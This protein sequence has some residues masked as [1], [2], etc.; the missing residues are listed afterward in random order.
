M[1]CCYQVTKFVS[2]RSGSATA[3]SAWGP[4]NFGPF[5]DFAISVFRE[6]SQPLRDLRIQRV[7]PFCRGFLFYLVFGFLVAWVSLGRPDLSSTEFDTCTGEVSL[8]ISS[9]RCRVSISLTVGEEDEVE[10]DDEE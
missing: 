3:S 10:E 2:T 1:I 9:S 8:L 6:M 5:T 7:A 4:C